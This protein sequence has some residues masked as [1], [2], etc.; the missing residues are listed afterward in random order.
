MSSPVES[1]L[2]VRG[3]ERATEM[4]QSVRDYLVDDEARAATL[5]EMGLDPKPSSRPLNSASH[6]VFRRILLI[7]TGWIGS[8]CW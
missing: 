8:R 2:L 1:N 6:R 3:L 5:R 4:L 7:P